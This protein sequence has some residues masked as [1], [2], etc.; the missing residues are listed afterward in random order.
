MLVLLLALPFVV[1]GAVVAFLIISIG[2][3]TRPSK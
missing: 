2:N 1:L 3:E